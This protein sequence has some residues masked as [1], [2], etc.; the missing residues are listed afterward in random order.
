MF[1]ALAVLGVVL[2]L[3]PTTPFLL[4]TSWCL[5]RSQPAWNE[6]LYRTRLF[7]P[8]LRD[9]DEQHGVRLAVKV[10]AVSMIGCAV[11]LTLAFG[12]LSRTANASLLVLATIGVV[13]VVRLPRVP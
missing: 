5:L 1:F 3:L 4:L 6:W 7:G 10:T 11:A 8:L 9:W 12:D 2:P 13:V